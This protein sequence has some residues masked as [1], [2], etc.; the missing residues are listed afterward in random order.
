[1]PRR[2]K[3]HA[4]LPHEANA[5][6]A[7]AVDALRD[8]GYMSRRELNVIAGS[9]ELE[10]AWAAVFTHDLTTARTEFQAAGRSSSDAVAAMGLLGLLQLSTAESPGIVAMCERYADQWRASPDAVVR[11]AGIHALMISAAHR[12]DGIEALREAARRAED[13][14]ELT[15]TAAD[16][17]LEIGRWWLRR[18]L[19]EPARSPEA[20]ALAAHAVQ[21]YDAVVSRAAGTDDVA[22]Q[23]IVQ[24]AVND[25]TQ[26]LIRQLAWTRDMA[27]SRQAIGTSI[28]PDAP[29]L[30]RVT[31]ARAWLTHGRLLFDRC[32]TTEPAAKA[33]AELRR[34]FDDD[35]SR[36][37]QEVCREAHELEEL[38]RRTHRRHRHGWAWV[39]PHMDIKIPLIGYERRVWG[40]KTLISLPVLLLLLAA[41]GLWPVSR[42]LLEGISAVDEAREQALDSAS[43]V[44]FLAAAAVMALGWLVVNVP[45]LLR[46]DAAGWQHLGL[47]LIGALALAGFVFAGGQITGLFE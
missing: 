7:S 38:A 9:P 33:F 22:L 2:H 11:A 25:R 47:G 12:P 23:I 45:K 17:R 40:W 1:V 8:D 4:A 35:T 37:V 46:G 5:E 19:D 15:V 44:I 18:W 39:S 6:I 13:D 32:D 3:P 27:S 36:E 28:T 29:V 42:R 41:L 43:T 31:V 24:L 20:D 21:A 10:R 14:P 30:L 26:L 16:A 34:R